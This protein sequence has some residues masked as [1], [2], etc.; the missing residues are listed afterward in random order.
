MKTLIIIPTFNEKMNIKPL[1]DEILKLDKTTF[2]LFVDDNSKDGTL[3][4]INEIKK[5]KPNVFLIKRQNKMGLASAYMEGFDFALRNNF[6]YIIQMDADFSHNPKY[7]KDMKENLEK[8]DFVIGSRNVENGGSLN[9]H[10]IRKFISKMGSLYA[11]AI[12]FCPIKD[13]TSGFVGYRKEVLSNIDFKKIISKGFC[14]QIEMKYKAFKKGFTFKE[15]PIIFENRR[16]GK[17]KMSLLIFFEGF[18]NVIKIR[19]NKDEKTK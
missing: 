6:D 19:L 15:F 2:I 12:L 4:S 16:F 5:E 18:I 9:W 8:Y 17:S 14:F 7:L 11:Q 3:T 13:L 10:F 1:V